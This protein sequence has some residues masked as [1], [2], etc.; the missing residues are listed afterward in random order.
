MVVS[1]LPAVRLLETSP[2]W[3]AKLPNVKINRCLDEVG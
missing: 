2:S 1:C 3:S